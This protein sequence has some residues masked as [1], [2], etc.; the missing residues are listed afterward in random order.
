V[1]HHSGTTKCLTTISNGKRPS[2]SLMKEKSTHNRRFIATIVLVWF[3]ITCATVLNA[4]SDFS[5]VTTVCAIASQPEKFDGQS[6]TVDARVFSDGEHGSFI[7]DESCG[8][9]GLGLFVVAGAKGKDQ[10]DAALGWCHRSTRGKSISGRFTGVFH[11]RPTYIGDTER[12]TI[13]IDQV[14]NLVLKSTRTVSASFPTPCP[15]APPIESLIH[16][17]SQ[18]ARQVE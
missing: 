13:S 3:A 12:R 1:V 7:Y 6:V 5:S 2:P 9:Y 11:F 4:Q 18:N 17:W 10:L 15:D 14:K 8:Q 16:P